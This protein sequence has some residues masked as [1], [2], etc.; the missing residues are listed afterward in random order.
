MRDLV[1]K[2]VRLLSNIQSHGAVHVLHWLSIFQL[3]ELVVGYKTHFRSG[4]Y[5]WFRDTSLLLSGDVSF[6]CDND[7][8]WWQTQVVCFCRCRCYRPRNCIHNHNDV[9][10][11]DLP[12]LQEQNLS[13][14]ANSYCVRLSCQ[15]T[16]GLSYEARGKPFL[17]DSSFP[18]SSKT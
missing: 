12:E 13:S 10:Q 11:Q 18:R 14:F 9:F 16:H 2:G 17:E 8:S 5:L 15:V 7:L 4:K 6:G 3:L 1:E